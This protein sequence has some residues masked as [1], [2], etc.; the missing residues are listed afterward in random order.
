MKLEVILTEA[1]CQVNLTP[2]SD[3]EHHLLALV[4][5]GTTFTA[6][7]GECHYAH[8]QAGFMRQFE[9][10]ADRQSLLLTR[11]KEEVADE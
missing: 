6:H 4:A 9:D 11:D 8:C 10:K 5:E 1:G 7:H 2:E 3:Y